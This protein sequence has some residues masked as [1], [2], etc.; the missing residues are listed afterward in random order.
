MASAAAAWQPSAEGLGQLVQLLT[1]SQLADNRT[2]RAIQQQ[3]TAFNAIPDFNNYLTYIFF[4]LHDQP[5]A[6]RQMAGLVLKNNVKEHWDELHPSVQE[7]VKQ[8]VLSCVG[9]PEPY[10]RLTAGTCVTTIAYTAGLA[11]WS[12]LVPTLLG[13]LDGA[14][15]TAGGDRARDTAEGAMAA[16]SKICEDSCEALATQTESQPLLGPLLATLIPIINAKHPPL[17]R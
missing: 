3:L 6:V 8:G 16:L 1:S 7:Y 2:H 11:A 14:H 5:G 13:M 4:A 10:L 17:R 9:S 12:E 15:D